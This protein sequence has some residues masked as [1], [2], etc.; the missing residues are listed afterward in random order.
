MVKLLSGQGNGTLT[1]TNGQ[2]TLNL[3]P[4]IAVVKQALV[5]ARVLAGLQHP[6]RQRDG[7]AVP[8]QGAREGP[9]YRLVSDLKIVLPILSLV[10]LAAGVFVAR[11]RRR[12]LIGV[13][14]GVAASM[15]VLAIGLLIARAIYL[16]SVP[17]SVL[18]TD[19]AA[20]AFDA[21]V[22]F[23]RQGLR[24]VLAVGLVI[25][26]GALITGPSRAAVRTRASVG[27][28]IT[29][30]RNLGERRGV[31]GAR[32]ASGP[33]GTAEGCGSGR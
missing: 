29:W 11:G 33:T 25:A 15:V 5:F 6:H 20:A 1:S 31:S 10:L 14:L 26:I 19:A 7:A 13:G 23:L 28:G 4:L 17:A 18:P 30:L 9:G 8:G 32:S 2:I 3:A 27:S 12:A 24:V 16:N 21:L 22:H